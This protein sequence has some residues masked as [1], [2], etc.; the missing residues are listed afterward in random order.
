MGQSFASRGERGKGRLAG[1]ERRRF[2]SIITA[3]ARHVSK[4]MSS[5]IQELSFT[6]DFDSARLL[7]NVYPENLRSL[8]PFAFFTA[9]A[10][11]D[12]L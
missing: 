11:S 2:F 7:F 5:R 10:R 4:L 3:R 8:S 6:L 12:I 9:Y 1:K